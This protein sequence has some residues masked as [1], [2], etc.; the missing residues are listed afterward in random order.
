MRKPYKPIP[1]HDYHRKTNLELEYIL[2]DANQA[3]IAM[4]GVNADAE[5]KYLDQINDAATVLAYRARGGKIAAAP[6]GPDDA[7]ADMDQSTYDRF[8]KAG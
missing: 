5:A 1:H 4:R 6:S 3:A 7:P 8:Y 2:E